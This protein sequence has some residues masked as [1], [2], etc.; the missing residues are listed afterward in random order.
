MNEQKNIG[1]S[2]G[3]TL[4]HIL[5]VKG[6]GIN[7]IAKKAVQEKLLKAMIE[8]SLTPG[9]VAKL[10]R[11]FPSYISMIKNEKYWRKCSESAWSMVLSWINTGLPMREYAE[12]HAEFIESTRPKRKKKEE[13]TEITLSPSK[14]N[15]DELSKAEIQ[16]INLLKGERFSLKEK[17]YAIE[18]LLESYPKI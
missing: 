5:D 8:E 2:K 10:L 3:T 7:D 13:K 14:E 9:N 16:F 12:K 17:L 11:L 18:N 1:I 4:S 6:I 15:I